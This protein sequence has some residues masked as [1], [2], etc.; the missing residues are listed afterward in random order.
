MRETLK[1]FDAVMSYLYISMKDGGDNDGTRGISRLLK[2]R[3]ERKSIEFIFVYST[4]LYILNISNFNVNIQRGSVLTADNR[5]IC[6]LC[7]NTR[8]CRMR[9]KTASAAKRSTGNTI[10]DTIFT[11]NNCIRKRWEGGRVESLSAISERVKDVIKSH[12]LKKCEECKF[13][14]KTKRCVACRSGGVT[15]ASST[16]IGGASAQMFLPSMYKMHSHLYATMSFS[17]TWRLQQW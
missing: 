14:S 13:N 4:A 2:T 3:E 12:S 1:F 5:D 17:Y 6:V 8:S 16:L 10:F 7:N 9:I 15:T 11:C